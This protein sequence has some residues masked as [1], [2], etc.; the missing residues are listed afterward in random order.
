M[1]KPY[2]FSAGAFGE[3]G[4]QNPKIY[5]QTHD[6]GSEDPKRTG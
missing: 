1:T 2:S 3:N 4:Y 6:T 5:E